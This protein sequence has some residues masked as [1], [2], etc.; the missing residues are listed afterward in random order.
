MTLAELK[1]MVDELCATHNG[2][3][4]VF[5]HDPRNPGHRGDVYIFE[6]EGTGVLF[7]DGIEKELPEAKEDEDEPTS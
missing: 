2:E 4:E 1:K 3:A 7:I 5:I 6:D